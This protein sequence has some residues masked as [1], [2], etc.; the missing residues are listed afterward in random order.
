MMT[1]QKVDEGIQTSF[2]HVLIEPLPRIQKF[3]LI[4]HHMLAKQRL[5]RIILFDIFDCLLNEINQT[6]SQ[7]LFQIDLASLGA[8]VNNVNKVGEQLICIAQIQTHVGNVDEVKLQE[9]NARRIIAG[10]LILL[11]DVTGFNSSFTIRTIQEFLLGAHFVEHHMGLELSQQRAVGI[12]GC[13]WIVAG[14][15]CL[16]FFVQG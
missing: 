6:L 5:I 11:D 9:A 8:I 16:I 7:S 4:R 14:K 3:E 13:V 2:L 10:A 15:E 12:D 1:Y